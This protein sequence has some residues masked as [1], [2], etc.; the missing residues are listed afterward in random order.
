MLLKG[1]VTLGVLFCLACNPTEADDKTVNTSSSNSSSSSISK[2]T[3]TTNCEPYDRGLY[4]HWIDE[5]SNCQDTRQEVL[6][7]E[8]LLGQSND[9]KITSGQWKDPYSDSIFTD[10]SLLDI[11]HMIPLAEAHRSGAYAW[12]SEQRE[13]FANDLENQDALIAVWLSQNRSKGD[14]DP[15]EWLPINEGFH[16]EYAIQWARI[17]VKYDLSADSVEL[18]VLRNLIGEDS[19]SLGA[20]FPRESEEVQCFGGDEGSSSMIEVSS[21]STSDFGECGEKTTCGVM[22]SCEEATFFLEQCGVIRLDG[23]GDGT[24]CESVCK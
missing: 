23:D 19:T 9:C 24:P 14:R 22:D 15:S 10:P 2:D 4:K 13:S 1:L 3:L 5:D 7:E 11:D 17:K 21:S 8:N 12:T 16:K 20:V 18:R 6:N